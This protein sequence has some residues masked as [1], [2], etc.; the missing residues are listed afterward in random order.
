LA[1]ANQQKLLDVLNGD[2]KV[3][4][5]AAGQLNPTDAK[6]KERNILEFNTLLQHLQWA[7]GAGDDPSELERIVRS[8]E[9]NGFVRGYQNWRER[10]QQKN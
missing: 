7:Q 5:G 1:N 9:K 10:S 2:L 8:L 4:R 6:G 3:C